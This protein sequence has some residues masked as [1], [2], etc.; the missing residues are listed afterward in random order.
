MHLILTDRL[1]CPR[2][3]PE[4]GLILLAHAIVDRRVLEGEVGCANCREHF[5]V[6]DGVVDA[7]W[8]RP[9]EGVP[10]DS[11]NAASPVEGVADPAM[12]AALLGLDPSGA[13]GGA[14]GFVGLTGGLESVAPA[15][16]DA[17][18]GYEFVVVETRPPRGARPQDRPGVSILQATPGALPLHDGALMACAVTAGDHGVLPDLARATRPGGRVVVLEPNEAARDLAG[19]IGGTHVLD[20]PRALVVER[21]PVLV[22]LLRDTK[23]D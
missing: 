21:G 8:P 1:T 15:L 17:L 7:R 20:D 4:F 5:I 9:A 18:P 6:E 11:A 3:G 14:G 13:G 12:V 2:C 19:T 23:K 16:A 10:A 22:P